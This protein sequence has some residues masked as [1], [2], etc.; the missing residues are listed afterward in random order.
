MN[1][2]QFLLYDLPDN[3]GNVQVVIKGGTLWMTQKAMAKLYSVNV[4]D[5]SKHLKNIYDTGEQKVEATVSK[6]EI[7]QQ[8]GKRM[9]N[10]EQTLYML[11]SI[12]AVGYRVKSKRGTAFRIWARRIIKDYLVKGYAVNE[13]IRHEQIGELRQLVGIKKKGAK[14]LLPQHLFGD[15][16]AVGGA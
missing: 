15:D 16:V 3:E 6:M 4:P 10:R 8:E 2:I 5:I 1:E 11:K 12:I 7:V 9:V 14:E 13:R